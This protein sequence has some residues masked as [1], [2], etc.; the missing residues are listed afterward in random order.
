MSLSKACRF[1]Y[2]ED[3][4]KYERIVLPDMAQRE[5]IWS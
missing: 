4:K 1:C 3:E 5:Q 2:N